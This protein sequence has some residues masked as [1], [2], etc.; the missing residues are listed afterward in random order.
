M[1]QIIQ[2]KK[3]FT[4]LT[5]SYSFC[6]SVILAN[7]FTVDGLSRHPVIGFTL[8]LKIVEKVSENHFFL[9]L[10]RTNVIVRFNV[11][12]GPVL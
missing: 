12:H 5:A 8:K 4:S 2:S 10:F 11:V 6:S 9:I 7:G 1:V 3:G